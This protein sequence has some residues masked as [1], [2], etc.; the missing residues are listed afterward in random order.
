MR[1]ISREL[2]F[3]R[4]TMKKALAAADAPSSTVRTPRAAPKLGPYRQRIA[5]LVEQN[6]HMPRK[7]RYTAQRIFELIQDEGFTGSPAPVRVSVG[8]LRQ[9]QQR[10]PT[11]LPLQFDPGQDAQVDWG[12]AQVDLA[13]ARVPVQVL[14]L[15]LC[16]SR[17]TFVMA[18]PSQRQECFFAGHETAFRFFGG[19]PHRISY[20]NRSTAVQT[21]LRGTTRQEQAAFTVFRSHYRFTAHFCTP[22][23]PQE[24]GRVEHRVGFVRRHELVPIPQVA[25]FA[26]LNAHLLAWCERDDVRIVQGTSHSIGTAG[27]Q[28]QPV[29]RPLPARPLDDAVTRTVRLNRS[30]QVEFETNRSSVPVDQARA[31]LTLQARPFTI[32]LLDEQQVL[33][34]HPRCYARQ[35]DIRDPLHYLPL[36]RQRPGAFAHATPLRQWRDQWPPEYERLLARFQER[37]PDG[38]GVREFLEVVYLHHRYPAAPVADASTLAVTYGCSDAASVLALLHQLQE[39]PAVSP[40]LDLRTQPHL[41]DVAPQPLDLQQYDRLLS[42]GA[43]DVCVSRVRNPAEHVAP[44]RVCAAVPPLCGRCRPHEP[45]VRTVSGG[46]RGL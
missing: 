30:S 9:Q 40:P 22:H 28:E 46:A 21:L 12:E 45:A 15:T 25:S 29:L 24:N 35:Q 19:V 11:F 37:H 7:Q 1:T 32:T 17:R 33:A 3:S 44:D 4:N 5:D 41:Q 18:V 2:G 23:A 31:Q 6:A 16:Y 27:Q 20:D 8:K 43:S 13:G 10:P 26:D 34:T 42:Q 38:R 36:L 39:E 14:V